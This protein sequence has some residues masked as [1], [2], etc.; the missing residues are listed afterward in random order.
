VSPEHRQEI[1]RRLRPIRPPR[2]IDGV[3][4]PSQLAAVLDLIR[5]HGPWDSILKHHFSSLEE[6][7]ATTSGGAAADADASIVH[8]LTPTFRGFLADGGVCLH[9]EAEPIFYD[10]RFLAWAREHWGARYCQPMK[11]LFNVNG[12][13]WN[14]DPGHLDSPRFRGMGLVNTPTWL[15][16]I[17]GKSGLFQPWAIKMAEV[18]AWFQ[19]DADG[20]GFTFWPDGPLAP[21]ARLR[22]PLWNRGVVTQNTTMYHRGESNGP[23][24]ERD[25]PE[26]LSFDSTFSA[27]PDDPEGW[28]IRTGATVI[29]RLA[30]DRLRLLVHWDAELYQDLADL[31]RH[32]DHQDDLTP[33]RVFDTLVMDLRAKGVRFEMPSDPIRDPR[34]IALLASNYDVGPNAYP[35]EAPVGAHAA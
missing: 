19:K 20:G 32:V 29:A 17:M 11:L 21:P 2:V 12:P 3:L 31:K 26:G 25:N 9:P 15:L 33:D 23:V 10:R 27:D 1:S 24:A 14:H 8:F 28:Q 30:T 7:I 13:A 35:P 4:E 34:F 5:R 18:I 22:P 6:L 16:S